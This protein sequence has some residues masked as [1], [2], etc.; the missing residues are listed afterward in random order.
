MR[1]FLIKTEC[2]QYEGLFAHC[3][4]AVLD[5]LERFPEARSVVVRPCK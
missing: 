5:A 3:C 4:D 2:G 1:K